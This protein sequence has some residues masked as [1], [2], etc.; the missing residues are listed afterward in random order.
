MEAEKNKTTDYRLTEHIKMVTLNTNLLRRKHKHKNHEAAMT[1]NDLKLA[2]WLN[3]AFRSLNGCLSMEEALHVLIESSK[4]LL[5][6]QSI[7]LLMLDPETEELFIQ[8]S[9]N[10]SYAFIKKFHAR[11]NTTLIAQ[12]ILQHKQ[13]VRN[14]L[15]HSDPVYAELKLEHDFSS[16]ILTPIVQELRVVGILHCDRAEGSEFSETDAAILKVLAGFMS[17]L[18]E[19]FQWMFLSR[20]LSR[21]DEASKALKYCAFLE[22]FRRELTRARAEGKPLSLLMVDIDGYTAF[23]GRHGILSGHTLL[24]TVHKIIRESLREHDLIGRFAA[25]DFIVCM[26]GAGRSD[27]EAVLETI[28]SAVEQKAGQAWKTTVTVTCAGV[29]LAN[30]AE[31]DMP[32]DKVLTTL[33]GGMIKTRGNGPNHSGYF[34]LSDD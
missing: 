2:N 7:S 1:E 15:D 4:N 8:T 17:L 29:T 30:Q 26:G 10:I 31:Y 21:E 24:E 22:E 14:L 33:G 18:M 34:T 3:A 6:C 28:R 11:S 13:V 12:A 19:K 27:A 16:V 5:A 23:I 25:D 20:N 32:L 9:R